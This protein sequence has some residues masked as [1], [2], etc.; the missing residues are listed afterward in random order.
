MTR[1]SYLNDLRDLEHDLLEMGSRAEGMVGAAIE[2]LSTLNTEKAREVM[3]LDDDLDQRDLDIEYRC[4]R[5]LALQQPMAGD[6][7]VIG[8]AMK[9]ITDLE[10]IGD[11]SV[12]VARIALK[13]EKE[14]G[15]VDVIDLPRM[16]NEARAML[17]EAL[18]AYVRRDLNLVQQI[19]ERDENVDSMYREL[20]EQ[21]FADMRAHPDNVVV[22]GW[23]LLAVHHVERIADHV[24]N[25]AERVNFMVTG[26]LKTLAAS[27]HTEAP[28]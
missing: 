12:D 28:H 1:Q 27:H 8:T 9:I 14:F 7:R 26:E 24:V 17:N 4:L 13:I 15:E 22:D 2:A 19:C 6:L 21:L 5:L 18:S 20:R 25:I 10:R 16:G 23:L 3:A 11:L